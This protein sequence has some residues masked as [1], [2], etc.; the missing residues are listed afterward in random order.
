MTNKHGGQRENQTGRP[1]KGDDKRIRIGTLFLT[2][3]EID[4]LME[5]AIDKETLLQTARRLL[6]D[7]LKL[8]TMVAWVGLTVVVLSLPDG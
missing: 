2:P 6:I 4:R 1:R 7:C 8:N 5:R 3:T